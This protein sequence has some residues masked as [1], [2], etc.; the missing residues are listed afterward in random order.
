MKLKKFKPVF[1]GLTATMAALLTFSVV[2]YGVAD[3][4]RS[5]IDGALGTTS[6]EISQDE[7]AAV[8]KSDYETVDALYEAAKAH[9]V[10]QGEEGTVI[11][12]NDNSVLPL[13][14][15]KK[16]ALFGAAAYMP[17]KGDGAAGGLHGGNADQV[18][19]VS[20]LT[21]A[22]V[23]IESGPK[24]VYDK[25]LSIKVETPGAWGGSTVSYPYGI[26]TNIGDL[27]YYKVNEVPADKLAEITDSSEDWANAIVKNDTIGICVFQRPGGENNTYAPKKVKNFADV[28]LNESPLK[29]TADELSLV[30][31]AKE[32][33]SQVIVLI[34]SANTMEIG[35]IAKGGKNE[36]DGIAY[37]G[38]PNDFQCEGIV[39]VLTGKVNAT[40][41]L[42][43]TY[44]YDNTSAPAAQNF[45]GDYFTNYD[46]ASTEKGGADPRFP[47]QTITNERQVSSFGGNFNM[48]SGG[49][50]IVE[51][52]GIYVGYNYYE[53]RY[54]DSVA[55]PS[56]KANS[57]KGATQDSTWKYGK[58]VIYS[59]GHGLSYID[60]EQN[61][62]SVTVDKTTPEGNVTAEIAVHNKGNKEGL[63]LAQLY[64][65]QPYTEYDITN[66]VEKSAIMYLNS[67]KVKVAAGS[68][69]TVT[70]EVPAKY[71]ASYDYTN[72][73]TYILDEGDYYFTAAAGA[74]EAVNNVLT[75]QGKKVSDGMDAE[76]KGAV[77]V[78]NNAAFDK[79]TYSTDN[80][81]KV[82]NVADNADIN[83]WLP[84]SVTYLTRSNWETYPENYSAKHFDIAQSAKK[85][86]WIKEV[87]GMQYTIGNTGAVE[88]LD[89]KDNGVKFTMEY[90]GIDQIN[91]IT[92]EY[93]HKLVS[94][95]SADQAVGG[96]IHG[97]NQTDE[98]D[99]I[100]NA[101]IK[102]YEGPNGISGASAKSEDG[103]KTY[104]FNISS[105]TLLAS[106]FNP[107]LA[108]EWGKIE[109]DSGIHLKVQTA[110]GTGLTQRRT[111]YN[112]RNLEYISEDA[113]LT[114]RIGYGIVAGALSKGFL[115][116]PK[117]MGFNDQEHTRSG[118]SAYM[119]EQKM[120]ET[121]LR[122]FQGAL[123]DAHGLAVMIA[124]NRIGATNA[125]HHVGM[126]KHI[127][128]EEWGYKGLIST[129]M[130][131]NNK[132]FI[133]ESMIMA[134]IT[135]VADFAANDNSISAGAGGVDKTWGYLSVDA[136]KNDAKLVNQARENLKYQFYAFANS[137]AMN[138]STVHVTP[139][140][141]AAIKA[142]IGVSAGLMSL[143]AIAWIVSIVLPEKKE[144]E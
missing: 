64:V 62:T 48:Y 47:G 5:Q 46:I 26:N 102:Q 107:D 60:Y 2:G 17:Y 38:V 63:F 130:A 117:H 59:F 67:K 141:E 144:E 114:N 75:A 25:L 134:T 121:D 51:A 118:I 139:W 106:S 97:G 70:I 138:I 131:T 132:Y 111:P 4:Y 80:G 19:L 36:V 142:A 40:G 56:Y 78:W 140:W 110:W 68:T 11:M 20:S 71:L 34:N 74:H 53:T 122:G 143:A 29:L 108:Y 76:G 128:R 116:G 91:N 96:V 44:V 18:D 21:K 54:Y 112:A 45:G 115:C 69:A 100:D 129:D 42:P 135:Q 49:Y 98:Y 1:R 28:E 7:D 32:K 84:G 50:Y 94:S 27:D 22:G 12:K 9:A 95:I 123:D 3:S 72:A 85:D 120:R 101:I 81:Y 82:T 92:D 24:A 31:L 35:D 125:S 57:A 88:N 87:R 23:T 99:H 65:Q 16:V 58:E 124:F 14:S 79:A 126:L 61:I 83:Y 39:N 109:G 73:K 37:I 105:Q 77:K 127:V 8:F 55:N 43:D 137:T 103:T 15:G 30:D 13:A 119:T 86:E 66:K 136:I 33:C 90:V 104:N 10:K 89:G 93:W 41:A 113:M 133:A 52:E 6:I